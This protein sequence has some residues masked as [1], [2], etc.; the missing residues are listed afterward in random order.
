MSWRLNKGDWTEAYVFCRL[1]ADG[2]IYAG[3]EKL[4][5]ILTVYMDIL[6]CIR[7]NAGIRTEYRRDLDFIIGSQAGIDFVT[8]DI[9]KFESVANKLLDDIKSASGGRAFESE[10]TEEFLHDKLGI[11]N[12]K[13]KC[14][15]DDEDDKTDILLQVLNSVDNSTEEIGFSIKS[16]LG[17]PS[18]LFNFS[19]ASKM[20]YRIEGCNEEI[21]H[22][23]NSMK[24]S[25]GG[26][27]LDERIAYI[28]NSPSLSLSFLGSKI[29][30]DRI[31]GDRKETGPFF[32][33]NLEHSD[34]SMLDIFSTML[35]SSYGYYDVKPQSSSLIDVTNAVAEINPL[36]VHSPETVYITKFKDFLYCAFSGLTA[37]KKWDGTRHINGGYIDVKKSGEILYYRAISDNQFTSF[38]FNNIKLERPEH[39]S[40]CK[41]TIAQADNY[42]NDIPIPQSVIDKQNKEKKG[43][44]GYV[45][46]D[47]SH[48]GSPCYCLD[49]N[50]SFRFRN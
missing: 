6:K 48:Y 21:M 10:S 41:L 40:Y 33:W 22:Q 25:A 8:V 27:N 28:K 2:R 31:Y 39:G 29:I 1:L 49:I 23:L 43:D 13:E 36:R 18:T 3:N 15:E 7:R 12:V 34:L 20:V 30:D 16:H 14:V 32:T 35:L 50:F 19:N 5:K 46:Y 24:N 37:S 47:T 9:T 26:C 38:L 17:S 44:Y 45:Y 4:E 11:N 42:L